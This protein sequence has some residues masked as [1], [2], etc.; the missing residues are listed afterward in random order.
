MFENQLTQTK[1]DEIHRCRDQSWVSGED[2]TR[3]G[4]ESHGELVRVGPKVTVIP[5][6]ELMIKGQKV[7]LPGDQFIGVITNIFRTPIGQVSLIVVKTAR[8]FGRHKMVPISSISE[9]N[10]DC[11]L[12]SISREEFMELPGYQADSSLADEVDR[13]LWKDVV[14]R[15]TDYHQIGV[16]VRDG[17]ITLN[18]HVMTSMNQWRA[19]TAVKKISGIQGVRSYL[20]PDDKLLILVAEALGQI[21]QADGTRLFPKVE[22]GLTV[23]T[24]EVS[25]IALRDQAERCVAEIPWVRGVIN[26][27]HA[28]GIVLNP[29][30]QRFLQPLI[31][32]E[33]IFK[34]G[35]PVT[36]RKVV[37]NPCNRRVIAA[38][39]W[40]RFPSL[41]Q[42]EGEPE[43]RAESNPER[44][45]VLPIELIQFL[46]SS[47]GFIQIN[48]AETGKYIE[49]DPT[50]Y[51]AP[52]QDWLPPYPYCT[53][54]VLFLAQS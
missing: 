42:Q 6:G 7:Y 11:V 52:A 50:C 54:D 53:V 32:S 14:L 22:N 4:E 45:V 30:E 10:P 39:L 40:G 37:I 9:V 5:L 8:L 21:D 15:D 29:V 28:P 35:L 27:I 2:E 34:G 36:I 17:V 33:L 31:G 13:A 18:G 23:L 24:G 25:S 12:L 49:Y 16:Q 41:L 3:S 48:S 47:T 51:I 38:V 26:E 19:E 46:T 44:L 43:Y 20:I 1:I